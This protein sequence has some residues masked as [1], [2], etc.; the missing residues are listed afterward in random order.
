MNSLKA[1]VNRISFSEN[2]GIDIKYNRM[3]LE[4]IDPSHI[5]EA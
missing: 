5:V 1:A 4:G 3:G 2:K